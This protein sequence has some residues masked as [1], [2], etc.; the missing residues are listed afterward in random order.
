MWSASDETLL[1]GLGSGDPEAAAAFVRRYQG[2]LF[3]LALTIL[4]DRQAAEEAAQEALVRA[5]KHS[6]AYDPR[7]GTV[8][9]WLLS[10]G[11][12]VAIDMAR[13]RRPVPVDPEAEIA[14]RA[15]Y[16]DDDIRWATADETHRLRRALAELPEQQRRALVL[17]SFYGR[18]TREISEIENAPVGTIKT[19][20]RAAMIKLRSMLAVKDE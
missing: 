17:A 12:N 20:I 14:L 3:G 15:S 18:S 4:G 13:L 9:T 6:G 5:W 19:R 8:A 10:I 2:R 7:R 1:A 11:R 16:D